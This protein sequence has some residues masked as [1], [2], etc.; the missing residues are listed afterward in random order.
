MIVRWFLNALI[1]LLV[2]YIVPGV[3]FSGTWSLLLTAIFLGLINALVRPILILLTLP[4]NILTLGFF[5]LII[6]ALMFWLASTIVK[7]FEIRDFWSA[8]WGALVY[9]ILVM[10]VDSFGEKRNKNKPLKAKIVK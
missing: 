6:N 4:I 8:F 9:W 5:T 1:L 10:I 2:S 7:G 3:S